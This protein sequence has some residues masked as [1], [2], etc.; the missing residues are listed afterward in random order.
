[1]DLSEDQL[2]WTPPGGLLPLIGIINHLTHVEWRWIEGRYLAAP[3]PPREEEF[4]VGPELTGAA[5]IEAYA[6]RAR[7]TEEVGPPPTCRSPAWG[8]R[9]RVRPRT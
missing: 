5:A 1:M 2:R 6:Q 4:R 3:F 9:A 8:P 7:R